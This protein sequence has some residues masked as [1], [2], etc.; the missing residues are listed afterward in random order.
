MDPDAERPDARDLHRRRRALGSGGRDL[1]DPVVPTQLLA[2]NGRAALSCV[3]RLGSGPI[4]INDPNH[5]D[6]IHTAI[7]FIVFMLMLPACSEQGSED[8]IQELSIVQ[9]FMADSEAVARGEALFVGTCAGYCHSQTPEDTDAL[10]L[11]D[12]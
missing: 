11:F 2:S 9:G 7:L 8:S 6:I 12:M 1:V 3:V 4:D 10:F 5:L